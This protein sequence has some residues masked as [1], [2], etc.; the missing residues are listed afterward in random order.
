MA[1]LVISCK[2]S[3]DGRALTKAMTSQ[4]GLKVKPHSS[5]DLPSVKGIDR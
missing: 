5:K 3:K 1:K 4:G 2:G